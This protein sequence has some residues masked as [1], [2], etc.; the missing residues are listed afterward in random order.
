MNVDKNTRS[1]NKVMRLVRKHVLTRQAP[2]PQRVT[3]KP[4]HCKSGYR[5]DQGTRL[6]VLLDCS[7]ASTARKKNSLITLLS[8]LVCGDVQRKDCY[9]LP[10]FTHQ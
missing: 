10:I 1:D 2:T 5:K 9:S 8:D 7:I 6:S 4:C 3:A